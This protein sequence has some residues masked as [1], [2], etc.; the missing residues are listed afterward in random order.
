MKKLKQK[1]FKTSAEAYLELGQ[2]STMEL[3][4]LIAFAKKLHHRKIS[5]E[6]TIKL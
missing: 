6:I 4:G 1:K 2:I 5:Q 3:F